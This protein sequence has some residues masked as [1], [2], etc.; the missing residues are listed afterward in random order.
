MFINLYLTKK[1]RVFI[2]RVAKNFSKFCFSTVASKDVSLLK[3]RGIE[4]A[5]KAE[6]SED[7]E[8]IYSRSNV[9]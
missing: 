7:E 3:K 8:E 1:E 2:S 6:E 9:A 5:H 4:N